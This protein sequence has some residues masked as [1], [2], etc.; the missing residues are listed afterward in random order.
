[1]VGFAKRNNA[2]NLWQDSLL[3][4]ISKTFRIQA[5][6]VLALFVVVSR[7]EETGE[8]LNTK[9]LPLGSPCTVDEL[10]GAIENFSKLGEEKCS[11]SKYFSYNF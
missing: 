3:P 4:E 7:K 1:M 9:R 8:M 10:P 2:K 6:D 5:I 11:S